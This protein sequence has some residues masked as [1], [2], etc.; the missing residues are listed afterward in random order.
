MRE[1]FAREYMGVDLVFVTRS[2]LTSRSETLVGHSKGGSL[3]LPADCSKMNK[4]PTLPQ[5]LMAEILG[6]AFLVFVGAGSITTTNFILGPKGVFSMADLGII[7]LAF[8]FAIAAMVY[9]IGHIS[10]CHINPAVTIAL[11]VSR[12]IGWRVAAAYVV[13]QLIGGI[14]GAL[15]I[16]LAYGTSAAV[17][18]GYGATNFNA[19]TTGCVVATAMEAIGTFFLLFV[20]MGTA[21]DGR[22]PSG[23]A[24]LIIGLMVAG[25]IA[26]F[27]PITNVSL[28]PARTIGPVLVQ[29]AFGGTYD[30]THLVVYIVGPIVG[31]ILGVVVYEFITR[32]RQAGSAEVSGV[33][34]VEKAAVES[35]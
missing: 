8:A 34:K 24:G 1:A 17:T 19:A 12:R 9:T 35:K 7:A 11:A 30:L 2:F 27:G 31:A 23:W 4:T 16:A 20:I 33:E 29:L 18:L 32:A 25:E 26:A 3:P 10:G 5:K 14:L 15:V 21:V 28:N 13:A 6:T 22:A